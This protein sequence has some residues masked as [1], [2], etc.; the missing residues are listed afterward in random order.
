MV[1]AEMM[2]TLPEV[3]GIFFFIPPTDVDGALL[4]D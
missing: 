3:T 1:V 2:C 4:M